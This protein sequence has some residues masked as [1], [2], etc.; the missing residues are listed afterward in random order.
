MLEAVALHDFWICHA[1]FG[2]AGSNNDLNALYTSN[3]FDDHIDD[4][5][6]EAPFVVNEKTYE[7]D[8][9]LADEI[10]P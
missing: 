7:N 1:Y 2:V 5:T 4:I 10:Y 6:P 8:Y 9:Y 3:L